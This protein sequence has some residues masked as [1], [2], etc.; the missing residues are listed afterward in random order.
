M[1][2]TFQVLDCFHS[3]CQS[4]LD[5]QPL[6]NQTISC[7]ECQFITKLST[8]GISQLPVDSAVTSVLESKGITMLIHFWC[9]VLCT[10]C[11]HEGYH[12][13]SSMKCKWGYEW[14]AWH[15]AVK[16]YYM[17]RVLGK[18]N[19]SSVRFVLWNR[20]SSCKSCSRRLE[21]HS[22]VFVWLMKGYL[23]KISQ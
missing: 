2:F 10:Y 5:K 4:C 12:C 20:K 14:V 21:F 22:G 18:Q 19:T 17:L 15:A 23:Y 8:G 1:L 7:P 11:L 16:V 13:N 6:I 9:Y 3:F